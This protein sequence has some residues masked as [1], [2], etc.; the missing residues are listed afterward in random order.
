VTAALQTTRQVNAKTRRRRKPIF[1][2]GVLRTFKVP[3]I[4]L[5]GSLNGSY[6]S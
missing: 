1:P 2:V 6:L 5:N 3:T 4:V